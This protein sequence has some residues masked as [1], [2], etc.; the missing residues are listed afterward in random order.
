MGQNTV[1]RSP[2]ATHITRKPLTCS[3]MRGAPD[4]T[5]R[6]G[7]YKGPLVP[8]TLMVLSK[9]AKYCGCESCY[10]G[11]NFSYYVPSAE[12][13]LPSRTHSRSFK[14]GPNTAGMSHAMRNVTFLIMFLAPADPY[15]THGNARPRMILQ[16]HF[17]RNQGHTQTT[18]TRWLWKHIVDT[19]AQTRCLTFLS[20]CRWREKGLGNSFEVRCRACC[21]VLHQKANRP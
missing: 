18:N 21:M 17:P 8:D 20:S 2:N 15:Q 10:A 7:I 13:P 19:C 11:Y 12:R 16:A 14:N 4:L 5:R 6:A 3:K 9:L 1:P